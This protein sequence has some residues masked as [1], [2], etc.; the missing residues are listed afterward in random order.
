M[1]PPQLFQWEARESQDTALILDLAAIRE[2]HLPLVGRKAFNLG[3]MA[4]I[5]LPVPKGFVVTTGVFKASIGSPCGEIEIPADLREQIIAAYRATGFRSVAVRSSATLEDLAEASFAGIYISHLNVSSEEELLQ[6]VEVCYRSLWAPASA[7]YRTSLG[8]E[9]DGAAMAV[10]VQEMIEA[11]AGGVIYTFD[12]VTFRSE[13]LLINSVFGLSEPLVSG[14]V[15]G[16]LF[17]VDRSGRLIKQRITEKPFM[18]TPR[19]E[20]SLPEGSKGLPSLTPE[21]IRNLVEHGKA[22][23][24]FFGSPQDIEFAVTREGIAILQARPI[25]IGTESLDVKIERYRQKEIDRLKKRIRELRRK[26]KLTTSEAVFSSSNIAELLPTPTPMSFGIFSYIFA[27]DGGIQLGRRQLGYLLGDETSEGLF[28]LICGHPYLNLEIDARTFSIG[29]PLDIEG[30]I[31]RVNADP[32]Q[33]NY[34]ELGLYE[35]EWTPEDLVVRFGPEA[36]R[37]YYEQFL[38][39]LW[40]MARHGREYPDRFTEEV[41]PYLQRYLEKERNVDVRV[42]STEEIAEK[43][44]AYLEHLRTFSCVRFVIAARLGFFFTERIKRKLFRLFPHEGERLVGELLRGLEGSR[45]ARQAVDLQRLFRGAISSE[46]FLREYGHLASNE[47]EISLP[48]LADDP[49]ALERLAKEFK[50]TARDPLQLFRQQTRRRKKAED[51][52]RRQLKQAGTNSETAREL[53]QELKIAQCSLSLRETIKYYLVA[54]YALMRRALTVLAERLELRHADLFYLYPA[55]IREL[56]TDPKA[57]KEKIEQRKEERRLALALAKR[58]GMPKVIFESALEEIGRTPRIEASSEFQGAPVSSGEAVG[59]VR[60]LDP[61]ALAFIAGVD[62]LG[63]NDVIVVRAANLGMF[64][65]ITKAA[66]LIMETGGI[67]AHGA[68]LARESGIPAVVLENATVL[69]SEG[70]VVKI[71]GGSGK[72]SVVAGQDLPG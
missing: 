41:E 37:R 65:P 11:Q 26:G 53:F 43:I 51:D 1:G 29:I 30:Y 45:I 5:G 17:Q 62:E 70:I 48:R 9:A 23:E 7:S 67:L 3:L 31:D 2:G 52:I 63:T 44:H 12:P 36:G 15:S 4:E 54:E 71:D 32:H 10:I 20:V 6:A 72:V 50:G 42:L 18:S 27:D 39:F 40:G 22:I 46:E 68:C 34:P 14:Q 57:A 55:E 33:A 19:G 16:D 61:D 24:A 25:T 60:I 38:E 13:E 21:Q 66:G 58:K 47:L 64:L 56:L 59:T 8:L 69:L 35:Q 28:E 49:R